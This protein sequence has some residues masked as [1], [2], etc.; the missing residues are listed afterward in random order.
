L[1]V[2]EEPQVAGDPGHIVAAGLGD[3]LAHVEG[4]GG[5]E[6]L[7][8]LGDPVGQPVQQP[9]ALGRRIAGPWHVVEGPPGSGH[10]PA[11][12]LAA[13][14]R[15]GAIGST[16]VRVDGVK[17]AAVNRVDR[18]TVDHKREMLFWVSCPY[19]HDAERVELG[20]YEAA[21]G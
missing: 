18:L 5:G 8:V 16:S 15:H 21:P 13:C 14:L 20:R 3:G 17:A 1:E 11:D 7:R 12:V 2:G 9:P 10:R 6:T 4:L 19:L